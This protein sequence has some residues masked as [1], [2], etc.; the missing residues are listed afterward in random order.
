MLP[1][2]SIVLSLVVLSISI[3]ILAC[4]LGSQPITTEQAETLAAD[5]M[6]ES[7]LSLEALELKRDR[8]RVTTSWP[9][10]MDPSSFSS[11]LLAALLGL[12][13]AFP[14]VVTMEVTLRQLDQAFLNVEVSTIDLQALALGEIE[15][16]IL[17]ERMIVEDERPEPRRL[18]HELE[19][20]GYLVLRFE[21]VDKNLYV[22]FLLDEPVGSSAVLM[23]QWLTIIELLN[24]SSRDVDTW[25]LRWLLPD[26]SVTA[27]T[28]QRAD[29]EAYQ[30][31]SLEALQFLAGIK[32]ERQP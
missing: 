15:A 6:F 5:M 24:E 25:N 27:I 32:V 23:E 10:E 11:A 19:D 17:L 2:N 18:R 8:L 28:L 3:G 30:D 12:S 22:D 26:Y 16:N 14:D 29:N 13:D 9:I 31:G 1:E 4:S 7:M 20:Q 21:S